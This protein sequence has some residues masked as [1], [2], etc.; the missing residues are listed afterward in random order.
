MIDSF[1]E[2]GRCL[3]WNKECE[4]YL[5]WTHEE[6]LACDDPLAL[7]YPDEKMRD[8]VAE[9]I[10]QADGRFREYDVRT[11]DGSLRTQLWADFRLPDGTLISVGHD[12]TERKLSE[13]ALAES[14]EKYRAIFSEARDGIVLVDSETGHIF[15]CNPEF[16][17]Q[18]GRMLE[19]LR[20][21]KIWELRPP[22]QIE[23]SRKMFLET[24][25]KGYGGSTEL[26]FQKPNG[27]V[28]HIDFLSRK[29]TIGGKQY[30]KSITRDISD[31]MLV[32]NALTKSEERKASILQ[33]AL[34]CV[35]TMDEETPEEAHP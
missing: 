8:R 2:N 23:S 34:D 4:K 5:G 9:T 32:E 18:T 15:D 1:D 7:T 20:K 27:D 17:R 25:R 14:E 30:N 16:E 21:L 35:I 31:R 10:S 12:I 22:N 26:S 13:K 33:T 28:V 11:K 3:L 24:R 29:M 6:I 19:Q